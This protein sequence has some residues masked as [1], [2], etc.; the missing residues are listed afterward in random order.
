MSSHIILEKASRR[1]PGWPNK[2]VVSNTLRTTNM[3]RN[4]STSID[5]RLPSLLDEAPTERPRIP[6]VFCDMD[7][8]LAD[9]YKGMER[10]MGVGRDDVSEYLHNKDA[11][12]IIAKK[13]P[14]LFAA[15][16]LLP[17]AKT[18]ISGL[19]D[20]RDRDHIKLSILTA[21]P[22]QWHSIPLMKKISTTDKVQWITRFFPDIPAANVL[23]VT[24][25]DK[26][27]YAH[28]QVAIGN[29]RPVL[30]DDFAKNIREWNRANGMGILHTSVAGSLRQLASYIK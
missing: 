18:L 29:P 24:R 3:L 4:Y 2:N 6:H 11:W 13:K 8:V 23:V 21:I 7:G 10:E 15:L 25:A 28:S 27:R 26:Q 1:M 30:I 12:D 22:E 19:I 9:F 5:I 16:P 14:H 20:H 17:G